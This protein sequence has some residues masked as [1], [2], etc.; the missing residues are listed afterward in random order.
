MRQAREGRVMWAGNVHGDSR[1]VF[2]TRSIVVLLM[3]E[4]RRNDAQSGHQCWY[5]KKD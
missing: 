5:H 1:S 4:M 2:Q 3:N